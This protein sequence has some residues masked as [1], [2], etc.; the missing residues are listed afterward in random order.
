VIE[1]ARD[2]LRQKGIAIQSGVADVAERLAAVEHVDHD[3]FRNEPAKNIFDDIFTLYALNEG[4][5]YRYSVSSAGAGGMVQM[6]PSTYAMIRS[7]YSNVGLMPDFVEGMRN[8]V[9][10]TEAM[11]LYMQMTWNDLVSNS[12]VT[13]AMASGIATQKQLMAAG[14]NSNP[15]KLG[16]YINRG[17]SAWTNLIPR[18]TQIYLQIYDS[19]ERFVPM[20]SRTH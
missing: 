16:G 12:T 9:N 20:A 15:A 10:A 14:Y 17:G 18:E 2:R 13:D 1:I 8:H 6:I 19:L 5:T 11:L 7:R 4:Q 3:R